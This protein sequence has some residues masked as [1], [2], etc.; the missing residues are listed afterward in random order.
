MDNY[1]MDTNW[2]NFDTCT[3]RAQDIA[4]D[5]ITDVEFEF[6]GIKVVIGKNTDLDLIW[7]DYLNAH[8]MDWKQVGPECEVEY[9]KETQAFISKREEEIR[10][11]VEQRQKE[12]EEEII[13]K[14]K[15]VEN[16]LQNIKFE[17]IDQID[18]KGEI[19][20][21]E[22]AMQRWEETNSDGYGAAILSYAKRW[23]LLIQA[24][25]KEKGY[26]TIDFNVILE[27]ADECSHFADIEGIT[28]FMYGAAVSVLV[29]TWKYGKEL[30]KWHNKEYNHEG[31][32][33]VN[34]AL[35]TISA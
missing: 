35:L 13:I 4:Q 22:E 3:K 34:P 5:I 30:R 14:T 26:E 10:L 17:Y 16:K 28:G 11:K 1:V 12:Y 21:G 6:N 15:D 33:V 25:A 29:S 24:E 23:A 2:D 8:K 18:W 20:S 7:R 32:G 27:I 19:I 31:E 9:N